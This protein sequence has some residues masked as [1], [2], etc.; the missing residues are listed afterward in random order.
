MFL[1]YRTV[2]ILV[3]AYQTLAKTSAFGD[4]NMATLLD[5]KYDTVHFMRH[6]FLVHCHILSGFSAS[7]NYLQDVIATASLSLIRPPFYV[8]DVDLAIS[9]WWNQCS[10]FRLG[11]REIWNDVRAALVDCSNKTQHGFQEPMPHKKDHVVSITSLPHQ[12]LINSSIYSMFVTA[13][14][15]KCLILTGLTC[16]LPFHGSNLYYISSQSSTSFYE[17]LLS[18]TISSSHSVTLICNYPQIT[19]IQLI[20][21][22]LR[23]PNVLILSDPTI[24]L[25]ILGIQ[26]ELSL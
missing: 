9:C 22:R 3:P 4:L 18:S 2:N 16:Y 7:S 11:K 5:W 8:L 12:P 21:W 23:Q 1:Y 20:F 13:Y 10:L 6:Y 14:F 25:S 24:L 15:L 26:L 17:I 19:D